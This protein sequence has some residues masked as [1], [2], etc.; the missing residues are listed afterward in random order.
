MSGASSQTDTRSRVPP[1][2]PFDIAGTFEREV[3]VEVS[4][5]TLE[6][7]SYGPSG[8]NQFFNLG[9]A[10]CVVFPAPEASSSPI[11]TLSHP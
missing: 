2:G 5:M 4:R 8:G 9:M 3:P 1:R 10:S 6:L 7:S 11:L